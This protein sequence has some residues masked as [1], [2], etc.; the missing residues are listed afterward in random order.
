ML[1]ITGN[2][3]KEATD[4]QLTPRQ[5]EIIGLVKRHA[6]VTGEQIAEHLGISR[7]TIRSDLSVLI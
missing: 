5:I 7:P 6:P 1:G 2:L 3:Y 4:I